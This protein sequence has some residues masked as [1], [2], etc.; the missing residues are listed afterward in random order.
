MNLKGREEAWRL[1]RITGTLLGCILLVVSTAGI[2]VAPLIVWVMAPG[3]HIFPEKLRLTIFL[4]RITFPYIF[5]VGMAALLMG[6]LNSF[7]RFSAPAFAPTMLN[8]A[9]IFSAL[10][11]S[12]HLDPPVTSLAIGVLLGGI[13]QVIIQVPGVRREGGRFSFDFSW[14]D[15]SVRRVGKLMLPGIVGLAITQANFFVGTFLASF[16]RE[17]SVSFLY[18]SFRLIQIP[19]GFV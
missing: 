7:R 12:S 1:A 10:S 14:Q 2:V 5:L 11:L 17:G 13:G 15:P 4:T 6:I 3:F 18:Y 9:M 19:I 8:L 16:L